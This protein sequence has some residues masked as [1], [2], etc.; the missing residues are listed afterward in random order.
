MDTSHSAF[1]QERIAFVA[2]I[3]AFA[4]TKPATIDE[5][6]NHRK[7]WCTNKDAFPVMVHEITIPGVTPEQ[8]KKY[9]TNYLNAVTAIMKAKD[10]SSKNTYAD[11]GD[12]VIH[13]HMHV[14]VPF[15]SHRSI[16]LKQ[17]AFPKDNGHVFF[18]SSKE[19]KDLEAKHKKAIN[20]DVIATLE[21]NYFEF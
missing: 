16:L 7:A 13:Q 14:S 3:I 2:D 8:F 12:G 17:Y 20:G 18:T 5:P 21:C 6:A 10:P 4:K 11:V 1:I 9:T 15:V 19:T